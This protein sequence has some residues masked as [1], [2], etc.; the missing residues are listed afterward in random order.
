MTELDIR[1]GLTVHPG[2]TLVVRV[3]RNTHPDDVTEFAE[4][5]RETADAGGFQVIVVAADQLAVTRAEHDR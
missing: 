2:D 5:L 1:E 3:S 4:R